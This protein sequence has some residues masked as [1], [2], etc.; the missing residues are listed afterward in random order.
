VT[1][2]NNDDND[3]DDD[4]NN[5]NVVII[6]INISICCQKWD[7]LLECHSVTMTAT[8]NQQFTLRLETDYLPSQWLMNCGEGEGSV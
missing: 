6:T 7:A 1:R 2:G 3:D 8:A 4:N 5:N